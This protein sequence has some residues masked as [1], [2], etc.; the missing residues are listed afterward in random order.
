MEYKDNIGIRGK[1]ALNW[2]PDKVENLLDLGCASG[3]YTSYFSKNAIETFGV[4]PN[5]EFIKEAKEKYPKINFKAS[6]AEALPFKNNFFDAVLLLD[7]LEHVEDDKKTIDEVYRVLKPGGIL[8]LTTPHKS[9]F[10]IMDADNFHINFPRTHKIL[11]KLI[12]GKPPI[13]YSRL[14]RHYSTDQI[15]FLLNNRFDIKKLTRR[16][17]FPTMAIRLIEI[18][19]NRLFK[20]KIMGIV[21][22]PIKDFDFRINYGPLATAICIYAIKK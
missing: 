22:N 16:S 14:H 4:D 20:K 13:L 21:S 19:I 8:I 9:I 5:P 1:L 12:K 15:K 3:Y 6:K 17:S 7:V 2:L 18:P 10:S 11:Y